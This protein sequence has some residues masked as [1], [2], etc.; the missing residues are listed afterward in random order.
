MNILALDTCFGACSAAAGRPG[1]DLACEFELRQTGHA[2]A[3]LPMVEQVMARAQLPFSD[4]DRIA[5]TVGP[6]SFTGMRIGIAA[7]RALSLATGAP[8]T[9]VPTLMVMAATARRDHA[10]SGN[11]GK[12]PAHMLVAVDARKGQVYAQLFGGSSQGV[13]T[14]EVLDPADAAR[15]IPEGPVVLT[16]SGAALV[17]A[18]LERVRTDVT[19]IFPGLQP[20]AACLAAL[21]VDMAADHMPV[22]PL[23]L[24]PPDAK[25]QVGTSIPRVT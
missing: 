24:R 21:A 19:V 1:S 15:L 20:D 18:Q 25:P 4:L 6:G 3:L 17:A 9:G 13:H 12:L 10:L 14:A 8:V 5:V 22:R 2:E 23:Y 7:A 11:R 16:G